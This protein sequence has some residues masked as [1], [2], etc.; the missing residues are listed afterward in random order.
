[1]FQFLTECSYL[2][3]S[4]HNFVDLRLELLERER[5]EALV[6]ALYGLLMIL[7]QSDAFGTLHRRLAAIPPSTAAPS[8][9]KKKSA[10]NASAKLINF[11]ELLKH[12]NEV[13]EKH[14][15]Q[16]HKQ[17]YAALTEKEANLTL[18]ETPFN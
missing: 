13:Q 15:E 14:K 3:Y 5:N 7:P 9:P 2:N 12:F 16:K 6:R 17:R 1:M 11:D 10:G 4:F 18:N 8:S